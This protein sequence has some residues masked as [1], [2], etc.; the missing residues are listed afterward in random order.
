MKINKNNFG[1]VCIVVKCCCDFVGRAQIEAY[2]G[3]KV[4]S[5]MALVGQYN[6]KHYFTE[7]CEISSSYAVLSIPVSYLQVS[8]CVLHASLISS[9]IYSP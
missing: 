5:K 9:F 8:C 6:G 3:S 1:F 2:L 7:S 4:L